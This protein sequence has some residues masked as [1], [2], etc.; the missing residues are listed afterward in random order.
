L[1][2]SE[3]RKVYDKLI[4]NYTNIEYS[5]RGDNPSGKGHVQMQEAEGKFDL[6]LYLL[7]S[8]GWIAKSDTREIVREFRPVISGGNTKYAFEISKRGEGYLLRNWEPASPSGRVQ[9]MPFIAPIADQWTNRTYLEIAED[10]ETKFLEMRDTEHRGR[11][12]K[13]LTVVV[14][15]LDVVTKQPRRTK[16]SYFFDPMR[17]WVC[18]GWTHD[19]GTGTRY[20]ESHHEYEG[21]G[22]YPPLKV[23]EVGERDHQ[24]SKHYQFRW[25]IEFT[26]FERL[27]GKLDESEFTLSAFGL[28][29]PVG[30]EWERP[31][32]WYLWLMLA[33]VVCLV[34]GGVFYWISRRR[35]GGT[36]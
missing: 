24:D 13:Q 33:G 21:E 27:G 23:I 12:V 20:L 10:P 14:S 34:A 22:E 3:Y 35:A 2:L 29:E 25:R 1:F 11:K 18:V 19:I 32:R 4:Q 5:Y 9:F 8:K 26:R 30:V 7:R 36:N 6:N 17:G 28:P 15:H 31:V 16:K